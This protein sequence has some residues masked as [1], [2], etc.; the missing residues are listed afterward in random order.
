MKTPSSAQSSRVV[1]VDDHPLLR[2]S[3]D[4]LL[5]TG[6]R[7]VVCG[8]AGTAEEAL[9]VLRKTKPELAIVDIS[10][11]DTDGIEL[12]KR[13][14]AEFPDL[15]ILILSMHDDSV[16]AARALEAGANG[17][18]VKQDAVEKIEV[19]LD[20]VIKGRRYLSPSIAKG[21]AEFNAAKE[22]R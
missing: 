8:E 14:V 2:Q 11:P 19:A 21:L 13:I 3:L 6:D 1:I 17:Y 18:M 20:E 5:S 10:L 15:K 9:Q 12:S 7:F 16:M 4:R 22:G